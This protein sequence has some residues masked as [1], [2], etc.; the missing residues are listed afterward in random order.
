MIHVFDNTDKILT[1]LADFIVTQAAGAI[2]NRGRFSLVLSGGSS[3]KKLYE[4]LA[5]DAYRQKIDWTK[6][7]FFFGDERNVPAT[8]SDS[9]FLMA[10]KAMFE[11]LS[12]PDGQIFK[13]NT[14]LGPAAAAADYEAKLNTFFSG[15]KIAFDV[16]LL[17]LGD[18][19]H[20]A[21]LFP[22]TPVLH[23]REKMVASCFIPKVNMD[24]ITLTAPC[25][26]QA[27]VVVFL[28][29]GA[30][31][32]EAIKYIMKGERNI[33]QYPAQLI[34]PVSGQLHWYMDKPA[35][36]LLDEHHRI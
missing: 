15:A 21:S 8:H 7:Y 9:N 17:G 3:P 22:G 16:V 6:V 23:E 4:L 33:E 25:I 20:T 36:A 32:A 24:R 1:A 26:N 12:I 10:K 35:A 28:V 30:S 29:F 11:P 5:S 31:K 2:R 34:Q 13:M 19:A 14:D 27:H 18:D